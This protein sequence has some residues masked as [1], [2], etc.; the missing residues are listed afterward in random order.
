[1]RIHLTIH[2]FKSYQV[3]KCMVVIC[4]VAKFDF[5]RIDGVFLLQFTIPNGNESQLELE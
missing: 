1:M 5:E 4:H 2:D 3:I